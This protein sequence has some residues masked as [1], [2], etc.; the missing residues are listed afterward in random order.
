MHVAVFADIEGSFGI[1]RMR[2]CHSGTAEWQYGRTCLT[3]DVNH[4]IQG[5]FD[6]GAQ[7]VTVKDTHDTGF[8]CLINKLDPRA[9]YVG[10]HFTQPT[11]FGPVSDYDLILYV[12]IHAASGTPDSFFPHTHLGIF[13]EVRLNGKPV[14]EMDIYGGYLGELG[15]PVGLVS[16]EEIAVEQALEALPWAKSVIVDKQKETY[17][18]GEKALKYLTEGRQR[19]RDTAAAAVREASSM[20]PLMV[21]GPLHFKGIFRNEKLAEQFNT[22]GFKHSQRTVEWDAD[23]MFEGM[24]KLNKLTFFPKRVYPFRRQ[25][26]FLMRAYYRTRHTY[27]APKP[28]PEGAGLAVLQI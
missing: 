23:N 14:C 4:A 3:E 18:S 16:G 2:Q 12:A 5:A 11:F 9:D 28:N 27:F 24:E 7:K 26:T 25:L 22:W 19:L 13:S 20:K 8:N 1:W 17:T 15:V 10:G 6:G 21:Q